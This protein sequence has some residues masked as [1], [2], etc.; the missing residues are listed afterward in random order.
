[1]LARLQDARVQRLRAV[2]AVEQAAPPAAG[3][4]VGAVAEEAARVAAVGARG[5]AVH[6]VVGEA[7]RA[8][9]AGDGAVVGR[10]GRDVAVAVE[11]AVLAGGRFGGHGLG[12]V[13]GLWGGLVAAEE[14]HDECIGGY[15]DPW[16]CLV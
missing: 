10:D 1:M 5:H 7:A 2:V 12:L 14:G 9:G 8:C 13:D 16:C 6:V 4:A 3:R 15:V 11:E